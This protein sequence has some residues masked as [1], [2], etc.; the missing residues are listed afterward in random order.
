M[1]TQSRREEIH[2]YDTKSFLLSGIMEIAQT[3]FG[4]ALKETKF[5]D[6]REVDGFLLPT[7]IG[8]QVQVST[9]MI[10]Y[11]SIEVNAVEESALKMPNPPLRKKN[12]T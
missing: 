8:W 6:Y 5:G 12:K 2:Y 1:M 3:A 7:Q 10:H 9:G 4:P 11:S